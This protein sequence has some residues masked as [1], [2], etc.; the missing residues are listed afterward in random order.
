M[1][2]TNKVI[3]QKRIAGSGGKE[4]YTYIKQVDVEHFPPTTLDAITSNVF[5]TIVGKDDCGFLSIV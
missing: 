2:C 1:I 4:T 3:N 5:S